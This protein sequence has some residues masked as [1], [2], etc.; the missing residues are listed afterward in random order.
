MF[1]FRLTLDLSRGGQ[2][3]S[4][5]PILRTENK[6]QIFIISKKNQIQT[7]L[8]CLNNLPTKVWFQAKQKWIEFPGR[9]EI[10]YSGLF[11]NKGDY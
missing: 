1:F 2:E 3:K 9:D 6:P 11:C 5:L 8:P 10:K 7:K 4:K